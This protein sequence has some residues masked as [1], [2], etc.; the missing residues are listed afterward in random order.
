MPKTRHEIETD[1]VT[2]RGL[3]KALDA[4]S[5]EGPDPETWGSVT[6]L[7]RTINRQAIELSEAIARQPE[8]S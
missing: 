4:L 1:A 7:I 6:A 2:L 5:W 8:Q 3:T